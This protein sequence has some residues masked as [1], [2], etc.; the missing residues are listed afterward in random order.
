MEREEALNLAKAHVKRANLFKHILAV[1]A[2]IGAIAEHLG[3]DIE[4]WR[5]LGLFHDLDFD[6]T[7]DKP[8]IHATRSAEMLKGRIDNELLRAIKA[9]NF[10]YTAIQPENNMENALIAADAIS[11]LVIACA[12]VVPG[13][14][15]ARVEPKTVVKKFKEKDFARGCSREHILYCEQLGIPWPEFARISVHALQGIS[16]E[17]DL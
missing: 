1:E 15:L 3:E 2:I 9:H 6:E 17:L 5:L 14:K 10:E 12:L 8:E 16:N 4:R 13:K 11:G 7:Y